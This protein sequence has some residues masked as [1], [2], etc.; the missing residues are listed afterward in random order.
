MTKIISSKELLD[1]LEIRVENQLKQAIEVFQNLD[2][3]TLLTKSHSGGWSVAECLWHLTSYGNFYLPEIEMGI[4]KNKRMNNTFKS[5]RLGSYF[6][7][8]M[9]PSPQMKKMKAF[10]NHT[11]NNIGDPNKIVAIFI[12]QQEQLLQLITAAKGGDLTNTKIPISIAPFI[13]VRLGDVFQFYIEHIERHF[14][15]ARMNLVQ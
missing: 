6:T 9:R 13:R 14:L 1:A 10:K 12:Q 3:K 2:E 7:Q 5:G 8:L 4:K 11:P 15:Q